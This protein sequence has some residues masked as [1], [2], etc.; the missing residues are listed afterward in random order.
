[1]EIEH[2]ELKDLSKR[3]KKLYDRGLQAA[4]QQN[5]MYAIDIIRDILRSHPGLHEARE[6]LRRIQ[7]LRSD[8]RVSIF[9]HLLTSLKVLPNW[10]KGELLIQRKKM[11]EAL[12]N[13]E[14]AITIDPTCFMCCYV[15]ARAADAA[16]QDAIV[17]MTLEQAH[18]FNPKNLTVLDWLA[19]VYQSHSIGKKVLVCRQKI[20]AMNPSSIKYQTQ[21]KEATALAAIDEGGWDEAERGEADFRRLIRDKDEAVR[22]EQEERIV[23]NEDAIEK[24]IANMLKKIEEQDTVDNRKRLADLYSQATNY[25]ASL[26]QYR[27]VI[28]LSDGVIEASIDDAMMAVQVKKYDATIKQWD[29]YIKNPDITV[30]ERE[31]GRAQSVALQQGK[32]DMLLERYQD[33]VKRYP[34]SMEDRIALATRLY[35]RDEFDE[36]IPHLQQAQRNPRNKQKAT[37]LIAKCFTA[38]GMHD[39]AIEQYNAAIAELPSMNDTKKDAMYCLAKTYEAIGRQDEALEAFKAIYATDLNYLDVG[40]IIQEFY[41]QQS[42]VRHR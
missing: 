30:D 41:D 40:T 2:E 38:K 33:R 6:K 19:R 29:E 21:L 12:D 4:E 42:S 35:E 11:V 7:L 10:A 31:N 25:D 32:D 3:E 15:M 34:Q 5:H 13:G 18:K 8:V 24:L 22:L 27:K 23:K 9:R 36:A 39:M 16:D 20:L 17:V 1:M 26:E 14:K 28:E 37:V